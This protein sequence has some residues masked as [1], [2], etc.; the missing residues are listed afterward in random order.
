MS[1]MS[2]QGRQDRFENASIGNLLLLAGWFGIVAGLVEAV[3]L[4]A[5]QRI[6]W[7]NW[8]PAV[9]VSSQLLWISPLLDVVL[10]ALAALAVGLALRLHPKWNGLAMAAGLLAGLT[11]YDWLVVPD[12]LRYRSCLIL[13]IGVGVA[14]ARWFSRRSAAIL[15][16]SRRTLPLLLAI[17][18]FVG[19]GVP[20]KAW[21]RERQELR[22]LPAAATNLPNVLVIVVDTLRADHVS[23]DGY[24]RETTPNIDRLARQGVLFQN[25]V[26]TSSW[27]LPSHVSLVTGRYLFEHGIGDIPPMPLFGSR[28]PSLGGFPTLGAELEGKG[29]RTAAFSANRVYFSKDLGFGRGFSHFEDYFNSPADDF[30]RTL[31]GRE[32]ARLFLNGPS[33]SI[34]K[35]LLRRLGM[36]AL[37]DGDPEGRGYGAAHLRKRADDV[38]RELLRWVDDDKGGPRPFFAFLNYF[39]VHNPYGGPPSYP[40][41]AWGEKSV[42]DRYDAGVSYVDSEFGDLLQALGRRG[43]SRNTLIVLTSDH[44]ESLG[45]HGLHYHG[46]ALYRE[47]VQVPL[48]FWYPGRVPADVKVSVPVSN[49]RIAKTVMDLI[50]EPA[51]PAFPTASLEAL[52]QNPPPAESGGVLSELASEPYFGGDEEKTLQQVIPLAADGPMK[53]MLTDRYQLILHK[54]FGLQLYDWKQDPEESSNLIRTAEG[55]KITAQLLSQM[56]D[57]LEQSGSAWVGSASVSA[58]DADGPSL[59]IGEPLS[60]PAQGPTGARRYYRIRTHAG[61]TLAVSVTSQHLDPMVSLQQEDGALLQTCRNPGDD[62]IKPP[63]LADLTP[64]AFDDIC[65]NDDVQPEVDTNA[66]L[67]I[68]VPGSGNRPTELYLRVS[69]FSGS[70]TPGASYHIS[71]REANVPAAKAY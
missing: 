52:W 7:K 22:R 38:N 56:E 31:F 70:A 21:W 32:F 26:A 5:F 53:S 33:N 65:M 55:Q 54:K 25:A 18:L 41:P 10:F 11:A 49:V 63:G 69:A 12:H 4:L 16:L 62:R 35:R 58:T 71:V 46:H 48:I 57:V 61:A 43:L 36:Q 9:H 3:G 39:D 45:E 14:F 40:A 27:S 13:A 30:T 8:G 17:A 28:V 15:R 42:I 23:A 29:Y 68:Q 60:V 20:V 1:A 50:G 64:E 37:L 34:P 19:A 2:D 24:P 47:L 66:G 51:D 44:G 59:T 6:N 67:E